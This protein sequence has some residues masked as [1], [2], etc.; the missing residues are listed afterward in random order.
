MRNLRFHRVVVASTVDAFLQKS[1]F[2]QP[3]HMP[4]LFVIGRKLM[5]RRAE[6]A[7]GVLGQ[8]VFHGKS[9]T[10]QR[11]QLDQRGLRLTWTIGVAKRTGSR[12][13]R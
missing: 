10:V 4:P 12:G 1:Q 6:A 5:G 11:S 13:M 9:I 7:I 3:V 8:D 2:A